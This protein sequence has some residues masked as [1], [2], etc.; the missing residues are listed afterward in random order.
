MC[1][2]EQKNYFEGEKKFPETII[3][4]FVLYGSDNQQ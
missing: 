2:L 4:Y 3:S 1:S